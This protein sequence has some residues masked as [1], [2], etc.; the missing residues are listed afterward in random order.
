MGHKAGKTTHKIN[1]TFAPGTANKHTV[2]WRF[3]KFCKGDENLEDEH[4]D[5]PLEVDSDKLRAM[6]L[7]GASFTLRSALEL[8]LDSA[9]E[10]VVTSCCIQSAF[11]HTS[12]PN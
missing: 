3:K 5:W 11:C 2:Q 10:L 9:T 12:Q 1:N 4:S 6:T 8:L 7:F